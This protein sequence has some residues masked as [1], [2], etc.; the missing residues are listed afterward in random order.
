MFPERA[1]ISLAEIT[2]PQSLRLRT[3]ERGAG[4]TKACGTAACASAVAA[5]RRGLTD[6]TVRVTLPGGDLLIAW[7]EDDDLRTERT[8]EPT[9]FVQELASRIGGEIPSLAIHRPSLEDV[10]LSLIGDDHKDVS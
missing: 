5:A 4:L 2:G 8:H 9:R 6:R 3:W 1:N 10:Y 7:R